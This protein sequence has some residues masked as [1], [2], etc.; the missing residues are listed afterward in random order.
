MKMSKMSASKWLGVVIM[1]LLV[2]NLAWAGGKKGP[3]KGGKA[4]AEA[5]CDGK[6]CADCD[7]G[8]KPCDGKD[9]ADCDKGKKPCDA[10]DCGDCDK[11]KDCKGKDCKECADKHGGH[12]KMPCGGEGECGCPG[13]LN[14]PTLASALIGPTAGN[15]VKGMVTFS[16]GPGGKTTVTAELSGLTPGQQHAMHVHEFGDC[17]AA[18]GASAGGH[19]NPEGHDHG[20]PDQGKRHAGDF[21]NVSADKDGKAKLTLTVDNLTVGK[22]N[23]ILGRAVIVHAKADDGGQPTG[24]A[25]GRVACGVIGVSKAPAPAAAPAK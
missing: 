9:C 22:R 13:C 15:Q 17:S 18:D 20:L 3:K 8:K 2:A 11:G 25:G 6:D 10:K 12:A 16:E 5:P 7:K 19:Y 24:N 23:A 21:G 14:R 1:G 4:A